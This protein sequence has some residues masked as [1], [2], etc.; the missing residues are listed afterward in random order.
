MK[1]IFTALLFAS[2]AFSQVATLTRDFVAGGVYYN[3]HSHPN[4]GGFAAYAQSINPTLYS[5][6]SVDIYSLRQHPFTAQT[7]VTTGIA[8][9]VRRVGGA[10]VFALAGIGVAVAPNATRN[11]T[12]VGVA[13]TGGAVVAYPLG[14][15]HLSLIVPLRLIRSTLGDTQYVVGLGIGWGR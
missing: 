8:P 9:F 5:Y 13:Y 4:L 14:K 11:G 6:T 12:N 15:S 1:T 7:N 2:C 10:D 3:E